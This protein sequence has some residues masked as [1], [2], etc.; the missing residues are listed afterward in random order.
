MY[1]F[2][3]SIKTQTIFFFQ[4][5]FSIIC[6]E[7]TE[8]VK[9]SC[10]TDCSHRVPLILWKIISIIETADLYFSLLISVFVWKRAMC[11]RKNPLISKLY[12]CDIE[13]RDCE[14]NHLIKIA[15]RF[16]LKIL[17]NSWKNTKF[18]WKTQ[19]KTRKVIKVKG[20]KFE[21]FSE[22]LYE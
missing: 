19:G 20:K 1:N 8:L 17:N 9:I 7:P 22:I 12:F 18:F 13:T 6:K 5:L 16:S 3:Q 15:Q 4:F 2:S 14:E 21:K 11:S 10:N